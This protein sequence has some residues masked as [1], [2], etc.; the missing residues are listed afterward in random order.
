MEMAVISAVTAVLFHQ[1]AKDKGTD[2]SVV[3]TGKR[4]NGGYVCS[5]CNTVTPQFY[6][7]R[8]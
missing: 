6:G 7:Y 5:Y 3:S 4:R 2:Y 8:E 1:C